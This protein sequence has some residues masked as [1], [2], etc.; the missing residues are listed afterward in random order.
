MHILKMLVK[1]RRVQQK[2]MHMS[3]L[4][5]RG[6]GSCAGADSIKYSSEVSGVGPYLQGAQEEE[7]QLEKGH[8]LCTN[9]SLTTDFCEKPEGARWVEL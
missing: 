6:A 3:G 4:T 7:L 2:R 1:P 5:G 9:L 8:T